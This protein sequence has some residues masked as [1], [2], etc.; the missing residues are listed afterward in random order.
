[1]IKECINPKELFQST[2]Y[3]FSQ[4]VVCRPGKH[5]FISGQ[6]AWD[7]NMN[8]VGPNDLKI[9]TQKALENISTAIELAGGTLE[10]I[11]MLRIYKVKYKQSDGSIINSALK[12]YFGTTN[13]PASTWISVD[14]LA[15]EEFMIEIEAQ[16]II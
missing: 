13:P 10:N 12:Q 7:E 4:I 16:A 15:N 11:V 6:V 14:G 5:V 3:G 1:M 8:I 9:Q 2:Q